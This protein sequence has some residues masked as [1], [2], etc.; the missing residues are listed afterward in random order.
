MNQDKSLTS[1]IK[2]TLYQREKLTNKIQFLFPQYY[3]NLS[4]DECT[5]TL[6]Y[7]ECLSFNPTRSLA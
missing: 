7:L 3:E 2:T 4:L 6:K 1:S 5:E